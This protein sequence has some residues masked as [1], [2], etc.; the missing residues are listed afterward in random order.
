MENYWLGHQ[1][2]GYLDPLP[3]GKFSC[4]SFQR[5][6]VRS[7]YV[8]DGWKRLWE[9]SISLKVKFCMWPVMRNRVVVKTLEIG[10]GSGIRKCVPHM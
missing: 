7:D 1:R 6:I 5:S 2:Q 9:L 10:F 8:S 4:R 3:L